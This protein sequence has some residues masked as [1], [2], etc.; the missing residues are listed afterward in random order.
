MKGD[1]ILNVGRMNDF[2]CLVSELN[3]HSINM[4]G[5]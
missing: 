2:L 4:G 1:R 3:F 5:R